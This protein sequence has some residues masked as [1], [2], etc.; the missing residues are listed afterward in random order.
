MSDDNHGLGTNIEP[1]KPATKQKARPIGMPKLTRIIIEENDNIPPTGL[2]V[3]INGHSYLIRPG[4]EVSVPKG[5][6]D[7]LNHAIMQAPQIDP[8][9]RRV[10]GYRKR[11]RYPYRV[12]SETAA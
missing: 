1:A 12:I 2:F 6:I 9:S 11:M 7:V 3:G 4:E 10:V 8:T 5:V